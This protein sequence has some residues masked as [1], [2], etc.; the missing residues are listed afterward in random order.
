MCVT[1]SLFDSSLPSR[2]CVT[3]IR[4]ARVPVRQG[5]HTPFAHNAF[6]LSAATCESRV[7]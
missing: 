1:G 4:R 5:S 7:Y 3:S 2:F 6:A